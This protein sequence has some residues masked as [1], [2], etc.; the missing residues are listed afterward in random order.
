M[1]IHSEQMIF[2]LLESI[3]CCCLVLVAD[4]KND[5]RALLLC[6]MVNASDSKL[7]TANLGNA[8]VGTTYLCNP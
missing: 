7:C 4:A 5:Y 1:L 3:S 8:L 2:L 6:V